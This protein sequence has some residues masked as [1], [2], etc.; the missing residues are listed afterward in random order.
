MD[1]STAT[2]F[3]A[4]EITM[5]ALIRLVL[6]PV[7]GLPLGALLLY[8][9]VLLAST[10]FHHANLALPDAFDRFLRAFV[11]T[12]FM[13]KIHHSRLQPETDSNY[14]S[15][16]SVWDRIFGSYRMRRDPGNIRFGVDGLESP[17]QQTIKGL[18]LTPLR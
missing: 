2:R 18:L 3:H 16:L 5:S 9:M 15:L 13:H 11:V 14:S 8:D 6:I 7:I 10:Q 12:P 4:G 17:E 1:A